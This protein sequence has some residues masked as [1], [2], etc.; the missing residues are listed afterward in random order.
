MIQGERNFGS[1]FSSHCEAGRPKVG[2][3][4]ARR[5]RRTGSFP[6]F[7][8]TLIII[9]SVG[10]LLS[11]C[12]TSLLVSSSI[13]SYTYS[14][15]R[16]IGDENAKPGSTAWRITNPAKQNEIEGFA[17]L[18]SVDRGD[19]ISLFVSSSDPTYTIE[20]FRMGW[21]DG[22]GARSMM[23]PVTRSGIKQSIPFPDLETGLIECQW[24]DPYILHIPR[25]PDS[26]EWASGIYLVLLTA[27]PSGKQSYIIFVVRDDVRRSDLLFQSS[28]AT[29]QAYN[30]W[31]GRSLYSDPRAYKVSFN[32]PYSQGNG[33]GDFIAGMYELLM[34][35]FLER[36]GY[37]VTYSTDVDTHANGALLQLHNAFLSVGHDEYWSWEMR[38]NVEAARDAGL[39]LGFFSS[40]VSYWQIRFEPS[41]IT[42]APNRT[43][44]C[45]KS[46]LLDPLATDPDPEKRRRTT[47]EFRRPPVDRPESQMMGIMYT[48]YCCPL[49]DLVIQDPSSWVFAN[50]GLQKGSHLI[51][52]LGP[53]VDAYFGQAPPGVHIIAHSPYATNDKQG[54]ADMTVY[55]RVFSGSIVVATG[56]MRWNFGLDDL[57]ILYGTQTLSNPATI[58]ATRNILNRLKT[59]TVSLQ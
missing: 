54:H 28:V 6:E 27:E 19:D 8:I 39:N 48:D 11:G 20:V 36:E 1:A 33:S 25:S 59:A 3:C 31:G 17:S 14:A 51:G 7:M 43:I 46:S 50:T 42:M 44:V 52:L 41:S 21:Y 12:D 58:Q 55:T 57:P 5:P 32:R 10:L 30:D 47:T 18:T 26:T 4:S 56:S 22:M 53:E 15:P 23:S 13:P 40:N 16:T 34:L 2:T 24:D 49:G 37:D 35:R 9:A 45:F 29:Y 38:D